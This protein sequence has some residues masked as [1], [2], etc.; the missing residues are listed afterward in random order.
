MVEWIGYALTAAIGGLVAASEIVSRY[1]DD[2][3]AA[4]T[5]R[6][7]VFY[8]AFNMLVSIGVFYL[9][10]DVFPIRDGLKET[11]TVPDFFIDVFLAGAAAMAVLRT[12]FLSVRIDD[13]DVQ[14]GIA[15]VVEIFR[16]TIDRDVDRLRAGPRAKKV[17]DTMKQVSFDRAQS[18]LTSVALNLMQNVSADERAT[19]EQRVSALANESDRPDESK[20]LELGL[21]LAGTIGF[22]N[23]ESAV[24][25]VRDSISTAMTRRKVVENAIAA[26]PTKTILQELP[27]TCLSISRALSPDE[28][29]A[30]RIQIEGLVENQDVSERVKAINVALLLAHLVGEESFKSAVALL[31][32]SDV[33]EPPKP[34]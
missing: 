1:R 27:V 12:S 34:A 13:K 5:S 15:A 6:G 17:A 23:L 7:G 11:W 32:A 22:N 24:D 10:R 9:I 21:I 33:P 4:T 19:I 20:A 26:L 25:V 14:I 28:Q 16:N 18:T 29:E 3:W 8:M 2:P 30:L 31:D